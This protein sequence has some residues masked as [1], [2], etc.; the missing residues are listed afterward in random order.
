MPNGLNIIARKPKTI[1]GDSEY[2]VVERGI[3]GHGAFVSATAN[4]RSLEHGEWFWG[5]YFPTKE[6][7]L[8]HFNAR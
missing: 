3:P 8:A 5:H 6:E 7:A 1:T 4:P 2:I